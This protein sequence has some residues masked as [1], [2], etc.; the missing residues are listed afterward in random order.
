VFGRGLTHSQLILRFV[1]TYVCCKC[2]R[3]YMWR[4]V[5]EVEQYFLSATQKTVSTIDSNLTDLTLGFGAKGWILEE[6]G[7]AAAARLQQPLLWLQ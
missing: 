3:T 2:I 6:I 4:V 1:G 5:N 7:A